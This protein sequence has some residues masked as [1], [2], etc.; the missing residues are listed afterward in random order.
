MRKRLKF[1]LIAAFWA[2]STPV[3]VN[4]AQPLSPSS[5]EPNTN[6]AAEPR[7]TSD[8]SSYVSVK[9]FTKCDGVGDDYDG[10]Q[11]AAK[12][13]A[14]RLL[15]FPDEPTVVCQISHPVL[16]TSGTTVRGAAI[17]KPTPDNRSNP[18]LI[19][20]A[21]GAAN[22]TIQ[23]LT[24]DG[25]GR[26]FPNTNDVVRAFGG[27]H[28]VVENVKFQHIRGVAFAALSVVTNSGVRKS[29]FTDIGNHWKTSRLTA[30]RK[31]AIVFCCDPTES[32][33]GNFAA[34]NTLSDIGLDAM[35]VGNQNDF[36]ASGNTITATPSP[37]WTTSSPTRKEMASI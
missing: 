30:D 8:R 20:F 5:S 11:L 10:L 7:N 16:L 14:G 1:G 32:S 21:N 25:N 6:A 18:M 3:S 29:K 24:I 19:K 35:S 28:L 36:L 13:A 12:S 2:L 15:R 34:D 26:D 23:G 22:I 27:D 9:D 33:H 37:L 17:L 31:A 4:L